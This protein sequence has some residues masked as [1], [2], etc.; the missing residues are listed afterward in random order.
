[1]NKWGKYKI[2]HARRIKAN[3][4]RK[5][6]SNCI[7]QHLSGRL[8]TKGRKG[9]LNSVPR[10]NKKSK[11]ANRVN[12]ENERILC[13]VLARVKSVQTIDIDYRSGEMV[14]NGHEWEW[15]HCSSCAWTVTRCYACHLACDWNV[16]E[17]WQGTPPS[18]WNS[19]EMKLTKG[20]IRLR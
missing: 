18:C 10:R 4:I 3:K 9:K 8:A 11:W 20:E 6:F 12:N 15:S 2:K 19:N 16:N 1:M 17:P 7:E 5:R 13:F 14:G